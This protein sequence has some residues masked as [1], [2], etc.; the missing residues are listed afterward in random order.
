MVIRGAALTR[1]ITAV[2]TGVVHHLEPVFVLHFRALSDT[3]LS[4]PRQQDPALKRHLLRLW[5]APPDGRPLPPHYAEGW[6]SVT[7]GSRGGVVVAGAQDCIPLVAE[8]GN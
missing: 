2:T 3:W 5:L 4:C 8:R 1:Q 6:H 7:P